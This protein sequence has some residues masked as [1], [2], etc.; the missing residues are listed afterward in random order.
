MFHF[1]FK[2]SFTTPGGWKTRLVVCFVVIALL[3]NSTIGMA[4]TQNVPAA[5]TLSVSPDIGLAG[6]SATLAIAGFTPGGY[7]GGI[8]W[9]GILVQPVAIPSGGAA[10]F[11]FTV[12]DSAA[13]GSHTLSVCAG[14]PCTAQSASTI[15]H[16]VDISGLNKSHTYFDR[17]HYDPAGGACLFI[18]VEDSDQNK[19]AVVKEKVK[20][21]VA[22]TFP[23]AQASGDLEALDLVET[24]PDSGVFK[25]A[26]CLPLQLNAAVHQDGALQVNPGDLISAVYQDPDNPASVQTVDELFSQMDMSTDTALINGGKAKGT[27]QIAINPDLLPKEMTSTAGASPNEP[28]RPLAVALSPANTPLFYGADQI[29]Q[30]ESSPTDTKDFL[31]EWKGSVVEQFVTL[32]AVNQETKTYNLVRIDTSGADLGELAYLLEVFGGKGT[33]TFSS[34]QGAKLLDVVLEEQIGGRFV[35]HNPVIWSLNTPVTSEGAGVDGFAQPWFADPQI[36]L[37]EAIT[38][39]DLR[40]VNRER[41]VNVAII[42]GGFAGPG[43]YPAGDPSAGTGNPDFGS[44]PFASI[45]QGD[46]TNPSCSGPASGPNPVGSFCAGGGGPACT[47]HGTLSFSLSGGV[48]DNGFGNMGIAGLARNASGLDGQNPL[49]QPILLKSGLPYMTNAARSINAAASRGAQVINISS[50]FACEPFLDIDICNGLTRFAIEAACAVVGG[51]LAFLIPAPI[52]ILI[53]ALA[54]GSI[55]LL[56]HLTGVADRDLLTDAVHNALSDPNRVIVASGPEDVTLP[57]IGTAGPFDALDIEFL[58]C[59]IPGVLCVGAID[60]T[61]APASFNPIANG[62]Q[63]WA[64]GTDLTTTAIPGTGGVATGFSGTSAA[65]PFITGVVTLMKAANP[66]LSRAA[67]RSGLQD[68]SNPL[69]TPGTGACVR[70]LAGACVGFVNALA[71]VRMADGGSLTCTGWDEVSGSNDTPASATPASLP[72]STHGMDVSIHA[73]GPGGTPDEDWYRFTAPAMGSSTTEIHLSLEFPSASGHILL[74]L[75]QDPGGPDDLIFRS[76]GSSVSTNL[77]LASGGIFLVRISA[78]SPAFLN[79][80]C[81][82]GS[83]LRI[84][85]VRP[86]PTADYLEGPGGNNTPATATRRDVSGWTHIDYD[87]RYLENGLVGPG[88]TSE[89][90]TMNLTGLNLH[91]ISDVDFFNI[92]LPDPANPAQGGHADIDPYTPGNQPLPECG[93]TNRTDLAGELGGSQLLRRIDYPRQIAQRCRHRAHAA[94]VSRQPAQ[95]YAGQRG[96]PGKNHRLPAGYLAPGGRDVLLR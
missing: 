29:I 12:P 82:G 57:I 79:D 89:V 20:V 87:P 53:D 71:V 45:P 19:S 61:K 47:F 28:A 62:V 17:S 3:V 50:G 31:S 18:T 51:F 37:R 32:P 74:E 95:R 72:F 9:D 80:N 59:A 41:S 67:I 22:D 64:P 42:D 34:E 24:A 93:E 68:T 15:F 7:P 65:A 33:Y 2:P 94:P 13:A 11:N 81:Y 36:G 43:D 55:A 78:D 48:G 27:V 77:L 39:L 4:A 90:W 96:T 5:A 85:A 73:M 16:V 46:C 70:N 38:Y 92:A 26:A 49:M 6:A 8:L 21:D 86:G 35:M 66:T 30:L 1:H 58:P 83:T 76:T 10:S 75:F 25:N 14:T 88:T 54:C 69:T 63:I 60:G 23:A 44:V 84:E 52:A 56:F 40:D 91:S